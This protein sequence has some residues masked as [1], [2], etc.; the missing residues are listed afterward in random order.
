M[1]FSQFLKVLVIIRICNTLFFYWIFFGRKFSNLHVEFKIFMQVVLYNRVILTRGIMRYFNTYMSA[2]QT[3]RRLLLLCFLMFISICQ[4][5]LTRFYTTERI[6]SAMDVRSYYYDSKSSI[7]AQ[8][9][10][11]LNT[12]ENK[13]SHRMVNIHGPDKMQLLMRS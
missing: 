6:L 2:I 13:V 4:F 11:I 8:S 5:E 7:V 10:P 1:F 3:N 9:G 12:N